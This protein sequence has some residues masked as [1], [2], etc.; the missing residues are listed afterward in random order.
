MASVSLFDPMDIGK[1]RLK[2]RICIPPMVIYG[3]SDESGMVQPENIAH[4]RRLAQGGA[5][6]IIQ[7]ATCISPEGRLSMD[8]LGIWSDE[9][10]PGLR[11][12]TD[13]VHEEKCPI[14]VQLHH[15]GVVSIG[16]D[17]LC[18]SDYAFETPR[19]GFKRG[20]EMTKDE[21]FRIRDAFIAGAVRAEKAGYDG[22][23]LHGCHG[24]LLCQFLNNRVNRRT[25]EYGA[26]MTLVLEI[27][28]GIRASVSRDFVVGIRLGAFEPALADGIA[29][30]KALEQAG[31]QFLDVSYGFAAESDP[32]APG[33]PA[34]LDV[35]RGAGEIQK[36]VSV[37]VFA[38][39]SIRT[40]EQ[41]REILEKT[42][43]TMVDIGRSALVDPA[44]PNKARAGQ[45]PGKCLGCKVCQ[46]RIDREKCPGRLLLRRQEG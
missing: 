32:T 38:V 9:Q 16:A 4:Y 21:I 34:I 25:D 2:N 8:Q 18:P 31:I 15:A 44:W 17:T 12:I 13:A 39:N 26:P 42:G 7:E 37:P 11:A 35:I 36:A 22:V 40:P 41:A 14:F 46:W 29:H 6:L 19:G 33:D 10:I 24:Y 43:V 20:R 28:K 27:L 45:Q 23:E 5:G 3:I 30:A 1:V